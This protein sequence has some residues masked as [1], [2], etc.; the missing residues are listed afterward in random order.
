MKNERISIDFDKAIIQKLQI[1]SRKTDKSISCLV[2]EAVTEF[3]SKK[4]HK[5]N[6]SIVGIVNSRDPEFAKNDEKY[7]WSE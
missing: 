1:L 3:L 6:L 5:K 7:L 2:T 4:P